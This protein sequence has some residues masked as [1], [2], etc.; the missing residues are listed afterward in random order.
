MKAF[1]PPCTEPGRWN[2]APPADAPDEEILAYLRHCDAC[3]YHARIE[4]EEDPAFDL[5]LRDASRHLD[6]RGAAEAGGA[7]RTRRDRR[8]VARYGAER[9]AFERRLTYALLL[10]FGIVVL[11]VGY[12]YYVYDGPGQARPA[13]SASVVEK[14]APPAGDPARFSGRLVDARARGRVYT[15]RVISDSYDGQPTKSGVLYEKARPTAAVA[16]LP[17]GTRLLVVNPVN[18]ASVEVTVVDRGPD[19]GRINLSSGAAR[20]LGFEGKMLVLVD[21]LSMPLPPSLGP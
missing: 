12:A 6:A 4:Q 9:T 18:G 1:D 11:W 7:P 21:V 2:A 19:E 20:T 13:G 5:L 16:R 8:P 17:F 15:A 10:A 14:T 3:A